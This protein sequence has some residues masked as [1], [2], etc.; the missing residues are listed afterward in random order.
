MIESNYEKLVHRYL[1]FA[2]IRKNFPYG[3]LSNFINFG[4]GKEKLDLDELRK[5]WGV[6]PHR[7]F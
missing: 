4:L 7:S 3:V 1:R 5:Y 2:K 6:A